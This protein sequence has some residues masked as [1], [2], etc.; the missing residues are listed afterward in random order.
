MSSFWLS[1]AIR[2][3]VHVSSDEALSIL[4]I[5]CVV[6]VVGWR[7]GLNAIDI[8]PVWPSVARMAGGYTE[9]A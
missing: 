3:G 6:L 8:K 7:S 1:I 5:V 4:M 2:I 9:S